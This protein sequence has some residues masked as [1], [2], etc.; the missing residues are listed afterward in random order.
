MSSCKLD[1]SDVFLA[2]DIN[3]SHTIVRCTLRWVSWSIF[4]GGDSWAVSKEA[5][6]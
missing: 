6:Q 4:S 5:V 1:N 3:G 2:E